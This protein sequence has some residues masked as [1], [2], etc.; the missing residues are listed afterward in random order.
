MQTLDVAEL[1]EQALAPPNS[2][3]ASPHH[4]PADLS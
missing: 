1:L 3:P 4:L 2:A